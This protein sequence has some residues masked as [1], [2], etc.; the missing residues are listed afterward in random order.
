MTALKSLLLLTLWAA[1]ALAMKPAVRPPEPRPAGAG[2]P[3]AHDRS[4]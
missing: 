4:N 1:P 2:I 3:D